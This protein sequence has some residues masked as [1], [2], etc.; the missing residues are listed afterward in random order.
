[1]ALKDIYEVIDVAQ[2]AGIALL[3]VYHVF[4]SDPSFV[5]A[6]IA[7]AF[8]DTVLTPLLPLQNAT[9]THV[10]IT[11]RNLDDD[12]DFDTRVPSPA[13][14]A[15]VGANM[16][17]F[18]ALSVQMNRTRLDMRNGQKRFVAGNEIDT[19]GINYLSAFILEAGTMVGALLNPWVVSGL[20]LVDVC[21]YVILQRVCVIQP[22]PEPCVEFRLPETDAEVQF[23]NPSTAVLRTVIR[24]QVS[25]K[26]IS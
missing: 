23:F 26:L 15:R 24:S 14:G 16:T 22:P 10:Q 12:T 6:D 20:P 13:V 25:R 19:N 1:M 17:T 8:E 2:A 21:D 5:A 7:E 4:K 9:V 18:N 11:A 3:N